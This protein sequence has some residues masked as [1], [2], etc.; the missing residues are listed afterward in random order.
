MHVGR[1][2]RIGGSGLPDN[3]SGTSPHPAI[4]G[5]VTFPKIELP[6]QRSGAEFD[7]TATVLTKEAV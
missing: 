2:R 4:I 3:V 6:A 1:G 5:A 7:W